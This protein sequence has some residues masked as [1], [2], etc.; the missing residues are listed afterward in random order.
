MLYFRKEFAI[1]IPKHTGY[2]ANEIFPLFVELQKNNSKKKLH[3]KNVS[4]YKITREKFFS[5]VRLFHP[6]KTNLIKFLIIAI[7][8]N[9][10]Y[11]WQGDT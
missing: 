4:I 1:L 9:F 11:V 6:L 7:N 5:G 3:D 2:P 10:P 8:N